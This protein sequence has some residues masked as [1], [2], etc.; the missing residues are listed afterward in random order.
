M[1]TTSLRLLHF[2]DVYHM[3]G[4]TLKRNGAT[5]SINASHFAF[6]LEKLTREIQEKDEYKEKPLLLFSGDLFSPSFDSMNSQGANMVT[7]MKE[8]KPDACLPGNHEFDYK[9]EQFNKLVDD[10]KLEWIFSNVIDTNK[11][12]NAAQTPDGLKEYLIFNR[13][14]I[15]IGMIGVIDDDWINTTG[16]WPKNFELQPVTVA[17]E[18]L[19]KKLREEENCDIVIAL[20]HSGLERD[21]KIAKASLAYP[22]TAERREII[23]KTHGVDIVLGGHDYRYYTGNGVEIDGK[24]ENGWDYKTEFT[25]QDDGLLIVKSGTDFYDL[26]EVILELEDAPA[27]SARKKLVKS[28]KVVRHSTNDEGSLKSMDDII[29]NYRKD[30]DEDFDKPFCL[31]SGNL[32]VTESVVR[33]GESTAGNWIADILGHSFDETQKIHDLGK[34]PDGVIIS[35][36]SIRYDKI[37]SGYL[38]PRDIREISPFEK[39]EVVLLE[40]SGDEIYAALEAGLREPGSGNGCFPVISGLRVEWNSAKEAKSRVE[41]IWTVNAASEVLIERESKG[42]Y[43]IVTNSFPQDGGDGYTSFKGKEDL[44][45]DGGPVYAVIYLNLLFR[46]LEQVEITEQN[47]LD[48]ADRLVQDAEAL[49]E[50]ADKMK[51][52]EDEALTEAELETLH[53]LEAEAQRLSDE[54][55]KLGREADQLGKAGEKGMNPADDKLLPVVEIPALAEDKQRRRLYDLA[56]KF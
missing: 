53:G 10:S 14:G 44:C 1:P 28:V 16:G 49:N 11:P 45:P 36:G 23:A 40:L 5:I 34:G 56:G 54:S 25:S 48:R 22:A 51:D 46:Q 47:F 18:R 27:G 2:N 35:G 39:T 6:G 13:G 43:Y 41:K 29:K 37:I 42:P 31:L 17:C 33:G 52:I 21:I 15:K 12:G 26:S 8:L 30:L 55:D 38:T 50:K 4:Q 9:I 32:D 24:P 7:L 20:T 3:S 19:S